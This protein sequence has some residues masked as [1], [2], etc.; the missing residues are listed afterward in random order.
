MAVT[1]WPTAETDVAAP[2]VAWLRAAGWDVYQEVRKDKGE[3]SCDIIAARGASLWAVE[4]KVHLNADVIEQARWW[5]TYAHYASVAVPYK[6]HQQINAV[7]ALALRTWGIGVLGVHNPNVV[8]YQP[9][10]VDK[11][12]ADL[13][14][15]VVK[16]PLNRGALAKYLRLSLTEEQKTYLPAGSPCG[17]GWSPYKATCAKLREIVQK[18]P[19]CTL[20]EAITGRAPTLFDP[21]GIVGIKHHYGS[22]NTA[23]SSLAKW[24]ED[25]KVP[26]IRMERDGRA[27]KLYPQES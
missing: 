27:L 16:P 24:I 9:S 19:G 18:N 17:S 10:E 26:G 21:V 13:V 25:G 7:L 12:R 15:H 11:E 3:K 1:K 8:L 6:K 23:I 5:R 22:D 14:T 2:A 4:V 20:R